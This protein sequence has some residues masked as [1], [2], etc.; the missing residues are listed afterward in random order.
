[1]TEEQIAAAVAYARRLG[2]LQRYV[3]LGTAYATN[4]ELYWGAERAWR[5]FYQQFD[6]AVCQQLTDAY[7]G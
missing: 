3:D 6:Y 2:E 5:A 1:M 7:Y 4:H